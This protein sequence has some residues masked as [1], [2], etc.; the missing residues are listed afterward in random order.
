[1]VLGPLLYHLHASNYYWI[2]Y[3]ITHESEY[4]NL[5]ISQAKMHWKVETSVSI[6]AW[7]KKGLP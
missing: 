7:L 1:M 2:T 4:A 3:Y 6:V 5:Y